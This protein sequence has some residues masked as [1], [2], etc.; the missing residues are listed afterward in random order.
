MMRRIV[1]LTLC[2]AMVFA[3]GLIGCGRGSRGGDPAGKGE[4]PMTIQVTSTAF[5]QDERIPVKY[6]GEG[7]DISPPIAWSG[8]PEGTKELALICDDP[9]AP[10]DE[11]WVHWVI[12]KIPA[13]ATGLPEDLPRKARLKDGLMLQGQNSW[14]APSFGYRGPMPPKGHGDHHYQFTLYALSGKL[15]VQPGV[16]KKQLLTE[17]EDH[18]LGTGQLVG[19]YSR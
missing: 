18:V 3:A 4:K 14:P 17:M 11:P 5:G 15:V 9:D 10:T 12:Y 16:T 7:E 19:I 1:W 8:L 2:V 13:N 6:T